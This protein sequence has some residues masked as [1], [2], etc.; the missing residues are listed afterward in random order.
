MF[1]PV[2]D[3]RDSCMS[4]IF[5]VWFDL[6][7]LRPDMDMKILDDLRAYDVRPPGMAPCFPLAI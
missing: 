2:L 7:F 5:L 4:R 3:Y 1:R 6:S